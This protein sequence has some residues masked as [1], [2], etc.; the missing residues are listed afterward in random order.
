MGLTSGRRIGGN[1]CLLDSVKSER[2]LRFV[3]FQFQVGGV[4]GLVYGV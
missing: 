1:A 4:A 3:L 2:K